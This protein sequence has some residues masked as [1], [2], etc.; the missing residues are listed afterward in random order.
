MDQTLSIDPRFC[1]PPEIGNGGYVAGLL[2][3]RSVSPASGAGGG[4]TATL[5]G[6]A[7]ASSVSPR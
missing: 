2:A 3:R 4:S 1:G 7:E 6:S 5:A